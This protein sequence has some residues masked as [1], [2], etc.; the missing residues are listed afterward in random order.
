MGIFL[1]LSGPEASLNAIFL[2]GNCCIKIHPLCHFPRVF[3]CLHQVL[4][5]NIS[6]V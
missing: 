5:S 6:L 1:Y 2:T 4:Q 3:Y